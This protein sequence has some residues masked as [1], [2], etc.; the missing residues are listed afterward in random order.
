MNTRI[1]LHEERNF[2]AKIN[3]A[4]EFVK[5]NFKGLLKPIIYI[6]LPASLLAGF[7]L[8][9]YFSFLLGNI[10][11]N[12]MF[13]SPAS[14][15]RMAGSYFGLL[16]TVSLAYLLLSTVIYAYISLYDKDKEQEITNSMISAKVK[17]R[18]WRFLGYNF[19]YGIIVGIIIAIVVGI[20]FVPT[21][22]L[23]TKVPVL[24][25]L[26]YIFFLLA[27]IV[28]IYFLMALTYILQNVIFFE[29]LS[30]T[31]TF[32]RTM[33]LLKGNW[34]STIGLFFVVGLMLNV[35]LGIFII[36]LYIVMILNGIGIDMDGLGKL[37]TILTS[38]FMMLGSFIITPLLQVPMSFQYFNLVE[39]IDGTG[40]L[41]QIGK[42]GIEADE[43]DE[44]SY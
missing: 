3:A 9:D 1:E 10:G 34:W 41:K 39:K 8:S 14:I 31:E 7:F 19:V 11:N 33:K 40:I 37:L 43:S 2:S 36:P 44:K 27:F 16:I 26:L 24:G 29:D 38:I 35:V 18:F 17:S 13:D 30:L 4:F 6:A 23:M 32:S 25:I 22:Y 21:I 20:I 5:Q 12:G 42:I 28:V 15:M